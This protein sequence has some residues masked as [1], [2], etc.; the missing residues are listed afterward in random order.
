MMFDE[1]QRLN[2]GNRTQKANS[3]DA[4]KGYSSNGNEVTTA[5]LEDSTQHRK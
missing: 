5:G 4:A 3:I 2:Y 1:I